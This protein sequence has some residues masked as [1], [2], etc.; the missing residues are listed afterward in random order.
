MVGCSCFK[1]DQSF[2]DL[3]KRPACTVVRTFLLAL[4]GADNHIGES[5]LIEEPLV[6]AASW[7]F[8]LLLLVNLGSL[9]SDLTGLG[10][11]A[12]LFSH[13]SN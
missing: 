1:Y 2:L 12:V 8:L 13:L 9:L 5:F 7:L 6:G 3:V 10:E 4:L 11:G